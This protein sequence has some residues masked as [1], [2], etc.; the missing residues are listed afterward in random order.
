MALQHILAHSKGI[1]KMN[2]NENHFLG[3]LLPKTS[4]LDLH[5]LTIY[6]RNQVL[7]TSEGNL[8]SH[9]DLAEKID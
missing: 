3:E 4:V 9:A 8:F 7:I 6:N 5:L 1:E 2:I